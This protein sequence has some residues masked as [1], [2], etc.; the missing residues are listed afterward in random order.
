MI[1][2]SRKF[3]LLCVLFFVSLCYNAP[4]AVS[5]SLINLINSAGEDSNKVQLLNSL[6]KSFFADNP[7][8]AVIIGTASK[9]LAEKIKYEAGL[10]LALKNIG[11][12]YYLQGKYVE[13]INNWQQ[14]LDVYSSIGD[15]TGVA[16][17]LSNQGAVYFNQGDD[18]KALELH[19]KSLKMSEEI[20]D[21]LRILTSL[22]NIGTVYLNK[23]A[24]YNK[25]QEYFVRSYELSKAIKDQ[26][27]IG[28]SAVNLGELYYKMG[29]DS[30]ALIYL[31]QSIK[32]Y[33][34]TEDLPYA[35]N[36][37]GRVYVRQKE[38]E[39]ALKN[40]REAYEISKKLETRLDMTQSLIGLAQAYYAKGD[41]SSSI[42]TYKQSL[43]IGIP[44]NAV[45]EMKDAYEGLSLAYSHESDFQQVAHYQGLLL[46][47]K[48]T[49]YNLNTDKE[50]GTLQFTF[51]LEKKESQINL[52]TKDKEIRDQIIRREKLVR[53]S[54]IGGF[55]VV[56]LFAGV[57]LI[58][59]NRISKEKKRSDELLLNIL[60]AETAEELK[61]TGVAK[62]KS[63]DLVTVMFT[64]FKNFT[65]ASEKFSPEELVAEI[66]HC[67]SEF[68]RIITKY[69]IEKIKTI[70]DS[71][72]CAGGLPVAN[73]THPTDVL[74]AAV[75]M[76]KFIEY[77]KKEK[78]QKG[79]PF[80][81]LRIGIHTGAVVAGIVGLKKFAYDIWG[82]TV[83]TASRMES[84]G[85]AGKINISGNTYELV[86][87][88]FPCIHRGKIEAKNKGMI[89][90]Y[91]VQN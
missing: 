35:L 70:G 90:M 29:N 62:A 63:L 51:D 52:L 12:G 39:K 44:L 77:N 50:L 61:A 27:S 65:K 38:F 31:N 76:L 85:E 58:Q 18:A 28:T 88:K 11:I 3:R 14:A 23:P 25:A 46:A 4:C 87:D 24:T 10:A 80:F 64:D 53:N 5:D 1:T 49:I 19:L 34:G 68:D 15:V 89:D 48:D 30:I 8:S 74:S 83:N 86:K 2:L 16:N 84:S 81:E 91:F 6:S 7:D 66:N 47:I 33:E 13:A 67:Y 56:L 41:I 69:G 43:D 72:M 17:M 59:R 20:G 40:H 9:K 60:P 71:Y 78:E 37:I 26:Y 75:E 36:Y 79:Q 22:T 82:D 73:K 54:L 21:T 32:A 57:F 42:A 55:A 45:T